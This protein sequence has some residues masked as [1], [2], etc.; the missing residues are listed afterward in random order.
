MIE[1]SDWMVVPVGLDRRA[2]RMSACRGHC[3]IAIVLQWHRGCDWKTN[4][5][6]DVC[7]ESTRGITRGGINTA[8][9]ISI[10]EHELNVSEFPLSCYFTLDLDAASIIFSD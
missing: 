6:C 4:G 9:R 3:M 8:P 7:S 2:A 10:S 5:C 1:G